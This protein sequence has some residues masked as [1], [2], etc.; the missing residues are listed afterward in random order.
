MLTQEGERAVH[1]SRPRHPCGNLMGRYWQTIAAI[2]DL[3]GDPVQKVRI[4][5]ENL[6]LFKDRRGQLGLIGD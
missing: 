2:A 1:P 5:G 3:L 4:L 6:V